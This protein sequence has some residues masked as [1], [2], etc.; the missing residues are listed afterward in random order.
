MFKP[1]CIQE[2]SVKV[3]FLKKFEVPLRICS[4]FHK[5]EEDPDSVRGI[6][7]KPGLEFELSAD[8]TRRT[9]QIMTIRSFRNNH[10]TREKERE[11]REE[12]DHL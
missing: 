2:Q 11:E 9:L 8:N 5:E 3:C 7:A 6:F 1:V 10:H 12:F 4:T